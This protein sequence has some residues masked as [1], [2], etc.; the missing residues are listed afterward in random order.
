VAGAN[1]KPLLEPQS[2]VA[3]GKKL[4]TKTKKAKSEYSITVQH[5]GYSTVAMMR[6]APRMRTRML[7]TSI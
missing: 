6:T 3:V 7:Y 4:K 1:G 2:Q 5:G